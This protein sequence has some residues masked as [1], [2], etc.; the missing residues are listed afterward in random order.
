MKLYLDANRGTYILTMKRYHPRNE[1]PHRAYYSYTFTNPSGVRLFTG[2]DF[3]TY[4]YISAE[5]AAAELL[6]FLTL[7]ETDTD[8]EY[9]NS[10]TAEQLEFSRSDDCEELQNLAY[11][12]IDSS[13]YFT[14]A[15]MNGVY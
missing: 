4:I 7:R 1:E 11:E 8:R 3:S 10:Y 6:Q 14:I 2:K 5:L 13:W 9:F 15:A 12:M